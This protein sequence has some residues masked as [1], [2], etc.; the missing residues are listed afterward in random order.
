[1]SLASLIT[2]SEMSLTLLSPYLQAGNSGSEE[3]LRPCRPASIYVFFHKIWEVVIKFLSKVS[4]LNF[5]TVFP[6]VELKCFFH[7]TT[8]FQRTD[9]SPILFQAENNSIPLV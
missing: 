7:Y 1:M 5:P 9:F 3:I 8:I 4:L 6:H 2:G